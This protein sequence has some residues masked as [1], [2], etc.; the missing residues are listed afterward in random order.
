MASELSIP[1]GDSG[2]D[3]HRSRHGS[4]VNYGIDG[5]LS[6][7]KGGLAEPGS[8]FEGRINKPPMNENHHIWQ[9]ISR[10][11]AG[12]ASAAE[13]QELQNLL[14]Q[15]P[16]I[17]YFVEMLTQQWGPAK[18]LNEQ[19]VEQVYERHRQRLEHKMREKKRA[20]RPVG[21][22]PS[23]VVYNGAVL[24]NY[25][26][27]IIR[28][29]SRYKGLSFINISGLALGMA[30][31]ILILLWIQNEL[32]YDRFHEK[33]D[34]IYILY[35]RTVFNGKLEAWGGT[36]MEMAPILKKDYPQV[37]EFTRLNGVG[38]FVLTAGDRH[39]QGNGMIVD[40]GFLKM[41]SYPLAEGNIRQAL[42]SPRSMVVT[43]KFAKKIFP[44]GDALGKVVRIDSNAYFTI[45]GILKTL[46]NNTTFE[47]EYLLPW[48]YMKEVRWER[49]G[50]TENNTQTIVLLKPGVSETAANTLFR[51]VVKAHGGNATTEIFLH[52]LAKWR[53]WSRF[54]NGKIVG[55]GIENVRLFGAIA[56]FILLIACINYMNLSTA[57]NVKSAK[58]VGIRKVVGAGKVSII[59][60]FLGESIMISLLSGLIAV[61]VVQ[62]TIKEFNWLTWKQLNVPYDNPYFWFAIIGFVL[63][64]GLIAGSYPAFYLSTYKP[65]SVLKGTFR[66][67]YNL[68]SIRKILVVFQFCFAIVFIICTVV[69]YRQINYA[70]KRDPGYNRDHLAFAYINGNVNSKYQLIKRDLLTSGAVTAVTRSNSPITYIWSGDDNYKWTGSDPRK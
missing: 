9:L 65:I 29:L 45:D 24:N 1:D 8:K 36:P 3:L 25:I 34:R 58:E 68:V 53:L 2:V 32:S 17:Q 33:K 55:G 61:V 35:N 63:I 43:E 13:L 21:S 20:R 37:E 42:N 5:K 27:V 57:R 26:K 10:R 69:I 19:E 50:W 64:T 48:S 39:L 54:E 62:L 60:R 46:P 51:D 14:R 15:N 47:F 23:K 4:P 11:M 31:A 70:S 41:F 30:S 40:P 52:P 38:P 16:D 7:H 12:E 22:S 18:E 44:V 67:A 6:K 28:N 66:T 56:G 59:C 49:R